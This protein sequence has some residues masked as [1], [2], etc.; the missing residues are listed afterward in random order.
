ML[1]S[2]RRIYYADLYKFMQEYTKRR[3]I[4]LIDTI[5]AIDDLLLAYY[6]PNEPRADKDEIQKQL[7]EYAEAHGEPIG[8]IYDVLCDVIEESIDNYIDSAAGD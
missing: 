7:A 5:D 8:N 4:T 3:R 1:N 6:S 2:D